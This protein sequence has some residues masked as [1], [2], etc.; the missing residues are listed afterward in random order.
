MK[1]VL[2]CA[3]LIAWSGAASAVVYKWVDAQGKLQYGDRPPNGV[4][5]EVVGLPG[6][7]DPHSAPAA[8]ATPGA[9]TPPPKTSTAPPQDSTHQAVNDDVAQARTKQCT[10][11]QERYKKLIESRKIYKTGAD[12]EKHFLNAEEIDEERVAAK[13]DVDSICNSAT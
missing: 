10:E 8:P 13:R 2:L 7:R 9:T 6:A 12:G 3:W 11:A 1:R 4:T 5:A